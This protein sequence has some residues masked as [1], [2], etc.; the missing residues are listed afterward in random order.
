MF[1]QSTMSSLLPD[2]LTFCPALSQSQAIAPVGEVALM[3][4]RLVVKVVVLIADDLQVPLPRMQALSNSRVSTLPRVP[5]MSWPMLQSSNNSTGH[6]I[7]AT[8]V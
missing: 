6:R 2:R 8:K 7:I 5:E 4:L 1:V 3:A